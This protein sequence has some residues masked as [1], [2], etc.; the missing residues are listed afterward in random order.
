MWRG[1]GVIESITSTRNAQQYV[2]PAHASQD[3][4]QCPRPV[5]QRRSL[6]LYMFLSRSVSRG[7]F[8]SLATLSMICSMISM[9]C[10]VGRFGALVQTGWTPPPF[11]QHEGH[12]LRHH[13]DCLFACLG[14]PP[15]P[16]FTYLG[17]S[18]ATEGSVRGLVGLAQPAL[19]KERTTSVPART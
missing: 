8:I 13:H 11:A 3:A 14:H 4:D 18:K 7:M 16:I 10:S 5:R 6:T 9:P 19:W 2:T 15:I 1:R 12:G 17:T